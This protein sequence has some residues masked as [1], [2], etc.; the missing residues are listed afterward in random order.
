M[1][2]SETIFKHKISISKD[3]TDLGLSEYD[4]G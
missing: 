2:K 3:P 1:Q 4:A